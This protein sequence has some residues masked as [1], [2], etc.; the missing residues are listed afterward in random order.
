MAL[1]SPRPM[2]PL[3]LRPSEAAASLS[4]SDDFFRDAIAPELRWIRRGRVK[5]VSVA[6][7]ERWLRD[8]AALTLENEEQA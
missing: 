4:V 2:Q 8:N 6:E 5:L 7:L 1:T 3:A